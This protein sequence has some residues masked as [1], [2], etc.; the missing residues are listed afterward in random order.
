M[1]VG[2]GLP[3]CW[4][5]WMG[6]DRVANDLFP[7]SEALGTGSLESRG[8]WR[9]TP[10]S[11]GP[12]DVHGRAG[13]APGAQPPAPRRLPAGVRRKSQAASLHASSLNRGPGTTPGGLGVAPPQRDP[14]KPIPSPSS[15]ASGFPICRA[16]AGQRGRGRAQPW[17]P[18]PLL[19]KAAAR[20]ARPRRGEVG[21]G[22]GS[23]CGHPHPHQSQ[24]RPRPAHPAGIKSSFNL[25]YLAS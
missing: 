12:R 5:P 7:A 11:V 9:D 14:P 6:T 13:R 24:G 2:N 20:S 8:F 18:A 16:L 4:R 23:S 25:F 1:P 17:R 3:A 21:W 19:T 15:A 10:P 22:K